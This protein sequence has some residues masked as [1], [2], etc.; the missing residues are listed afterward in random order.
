MRSLLLAL[1]TRAIPLYVVGR[2]VYRRLTRPILVGVRALVID[3]GQVL[4]VRAHGS[5]FW[6]FPGGGVKRGESLREAA[7]REAREESGC[8]VEPLRLLGI[9]LNRGEGMTNYVALYIC[10][11]LSQPI[12]TLN[13]EIAEA[14]YWPL[15]ALPEVSPTVSRRLLDY[16]SGEYGL[17]GLW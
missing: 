13:I 6:E 10:R 16:R 3:D 17:E 7:I 2:T 1:L 5:S 8:V 15:D 9:Y 14:R 12:P 11:P 4:L